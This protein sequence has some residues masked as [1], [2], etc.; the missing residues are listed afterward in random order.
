MRSRLQ[1]ISM[2]M[3]R[4]GDGD[5]DGGDGAA[6]LLFSDEM[7]V[8]SVCDS[9]CGVSPLRRHICELYMGAFTKV[10]W[11]DLTRW[12]HVVRV[13]GMGELFPY[14]CP[15]KLLILVFVASLT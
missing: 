1:V 15:L 10:A 6:V 3:E 9:F 5:G 8:R 2:V 7:D 4:D 14:K 11:F 12:W 13:H